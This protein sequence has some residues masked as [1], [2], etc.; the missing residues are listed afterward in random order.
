[1]FPK[2][3]RPKKKKKTALVKMKLKKLSEDLQVGA[4]FSEP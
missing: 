4:L 3:K 2:A 1:V